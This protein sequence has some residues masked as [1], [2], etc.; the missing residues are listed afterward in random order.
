MKAPAA[1]SRR[2]SRYAT[3]PSSY[4]L[5]PPRRP[6]NDHAITPSRTR[7]T[8]ATAGMNQV[9]RPD[10]GVETMFTGAS[11]VVE[12]GGSGESGSD[13]AAAVSGGIGAEPPRPD[14]V[15]GAGSAINPDSSLRN[16]ERAAFTSPSAG[17]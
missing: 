15:P 7:P 10:V 8:S 3:T 6:S 14:G 12:R 13:I 2:P 11:K 1:A 9:G 17:T 5:L 4:A 16:A